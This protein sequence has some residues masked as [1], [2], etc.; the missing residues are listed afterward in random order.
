MLADHDRELE[1]T[2]TFFFFGKA[3]SV[4]EENYHY[5][6]CD[7]EEFS[8]CRVENKDDDNFLMLSRRIQYSVIE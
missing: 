2:T 1:S 3:L 4:H 6:D 5:I 8:N 7:F